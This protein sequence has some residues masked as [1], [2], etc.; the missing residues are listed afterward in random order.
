MSDITGVTVTELKQA[1]TYNDEYYVTNNLPKNN[2]T[3]L[4]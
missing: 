3:I 4:T 2:T 1:L